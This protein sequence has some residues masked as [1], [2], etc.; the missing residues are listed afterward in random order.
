VCGGKS[1]FKGIRERSADLS[2]GRKKGAREGV[3][4]ILLE[5]GFRLKRGRKRE[6]ESLWVGGEVERK[7]LPF[8]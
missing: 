5:G 3:Y 6:L 1:K 8:E 4:K 2:V 7:A